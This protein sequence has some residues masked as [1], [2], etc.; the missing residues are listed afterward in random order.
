[1]SHVRKG[2][3]GY[4]EALRQASNPDDFALRYSGISSTSDSH[5]DDF[6]AGSG[7]PAPSNAAT[8]NAATPS[9]TRAHTPAPQPAKAS[10]SDPDDKNGDFKIDRF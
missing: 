8:P 7:A 3:I 10:A 4:Q 1:M 9:G 5:W 6:D 2:Q